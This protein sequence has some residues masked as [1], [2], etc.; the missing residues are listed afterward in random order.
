MVK[1]HH[2]C[3]LADVLTLT[4]CHLNLSM[5]TPPPPP[6]Q[7]DPKAV[8]QAVWDNRRSLT[9]TLAPLGRRPRRTQTGVGVAWPACPACA[10]QGQSHCVEGPGE[11]QNTMPQSGG[12]GRIY[13]QGRTPPPPPDP[14]YASLEELSSQE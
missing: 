7:L 13:V 1:W 10:C 9:I 4:Q 12:G 5:A 3:E 6:V 2:R 11:A 8:A 14:T